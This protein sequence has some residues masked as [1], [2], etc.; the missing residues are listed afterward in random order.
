MAYYRRRL[1]R[2]LRRGYRPSRRLRIR[3]RSRRSIR[4][5]L[6]KIGYPTH[7][8][9]IGFT[10]RKTFLLKTESTTATIKDKSI[11]YY[12]DPRESPKWVKYIGEKDDIKYQTFSVKKI[13]V[14][15]TPIANTFT[16]A[17]HIPQLKMT[18]HYYLP[19]TNTSDVKEVLATQSEYKDEYVFD[20]NK[21]ITFVIRKPRPCTGITI[22]KPRTEVLLSYLGNYDAI[23]DEQ[24][25]GYYNDDGDEDVE[26]IKNT[27]FNYGILRIQGANLTAYNIQV[28]YK[29]SVRN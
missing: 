17:A 13:Y 19:G 23:G 3:S 28:T 18:Y 20:S 9:F 15:I 26:T 7:V 25:D 22:D 5:D 6:D 12:L 4:R 11:L 16:T 2:R 14:R 21:S 27:D 10:Q 8:K 24:E 1:F 29:V